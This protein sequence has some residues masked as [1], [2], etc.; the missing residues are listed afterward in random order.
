MDERRLKKACENGDHEVLLDICQKHPRAAAHTFPDVSNIAKADRR[1]R[2]GHDVTCLHLTSA[3]AHVECC[4]V[5]LNC[6]AFIEAKDKDGRTPLM[7]ATTCEV[8]QLL[9]SRR[10]NVKTRDRRGWTALHHCASTSLDKRCVEELVTAGASV[11]AAE[12]QF[13]MDPADGAH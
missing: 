10:A 8:V 5:L 3:Y 7:Y 4:R 9:L 1:G 2:F 6:G 11:T 12:G 13:W